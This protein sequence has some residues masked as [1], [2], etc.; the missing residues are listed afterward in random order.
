MR[1]RVL[2]AWI[3]AGA[4]LWAS[5]GVLDIVGGSSPVVRV[6]MLPGAGQLLV[7]VVLAVLAGAV[8]DWRLPAAGRVSGVVAPTGVPPSGDSYLPL[9]ALA[10]LVLPYLP[11]LPDLL[12][13]L[14]VFAGPGRYLVWLVVLS[15]VVWATFGAGRGRRVAAGLRA[16]PS[17]RS[18]AVV[19]AVST[20]LFGVASAALSSSGLFPG[21]DE[22]HYLVITQSLLADGDL[23]IGNN[24]RQRDYAPYFDGDLDPHVIANGTDGSAYS[25]H[26]IGLPVLLAPAVAAGGYRGAVLLVIVLAAAAA[27]F[28]WQWVRRLTGSVSA[29][30]F[31]WAVTSTSVPFLCSSGTIYPEIPAALAVV[32]A[33]AMALPRSAPDLSDP[34]QLPTLPRALVLGLAAGALPWLHAKYAPMSAA[35][36]GVGLWH[37]WRHTT[38]PAASRLRIGVMTAA[39]YVL[40]LLGWFSYFMIIWGSPWPSA[41]YGGADNTQMSVW[42]LAKG[43][44]GLLADQ[45]YGVISYAPALGIGVLGLWRLWRDKGHARAVGIGLCVVLGALVG[46][47]GAFQMWWG[48]ASLPGRMIVSGLMLLAV[49]V[50]W[51]Y[52]AAALRPQRRALY[53]LLLLIGLAASLASLAVHGG[54]LLALRRDGVSRLLEWLSP[55]WHLWAYAPDYITQSATTALAQTTVWV[56]AVLASAW[57]VGRWAASGRRKPGVSRTGRG[58]AFLHADTGSLLAVLLATSIMPWMP[59]PQLKANPEPRDRSRIGML[60]SFDPHARPLAVRLDPWSRIDAVSVPGLFTLTARPGSRK[61]RQPT[62]MLLNARFAL[63]AGRYQV[64][65]ATDRVVPDQPRLAG[66]LEL[67]GGRS[68][69]TLA[70]WDVEGRAGGRWEGWFD[71]P[72]DVN[73]VGFRASTNLEARVGEL[74]ITPVRIVPT[75]DRIAAYDVLAAAMLSRFVFLFHDGRSYPEASGF[76]V[77]GANRAV[78]SVVSKTGP[79]TTDVTLVLRSPVANRVRLDTPGHSWS[80]EL[81]PN[82]PVEIRVT[83]T[84][85]DGTLRMVIRPERGFS[86]AEVERGSQDRRFLGCWIE[87][88]G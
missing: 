72:V 51:E 55:D 30:T 47:V 4:A 75:A 5:L 68:G 80:I 88:V 15:Q 13:V 58:V 71:L 20:V 28:T 74:R 81:R 65:L 33:A 50:A 73:F 86:P 62:P 8:L 57:L 12:P 37:I 22:P 34:P 43:T 24:Y 39:P 46:T 3:T 56:V 23:R 35:L 36:L 54:S 38:L 85:L 83:P 42:S 78:V 60:D 87:V 67:M 26:P 31:G 66:S 11:W 32:V 40:S 29:A 10:V 64:Q 19:F 76:W 27:A 69:G 84:P 16:W 25:V 2:G 48:G 1:M 53:R 9:Y 49:P 17:V 52:R 18:F 59:G 44:A 45:E 79:V 14:R 41:A 7:S 6:A 61:A 63:P 70:Q 21:G 82:V 77:R